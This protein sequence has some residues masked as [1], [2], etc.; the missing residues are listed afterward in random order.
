MGGITRPTWLFPSR[1]EYGV[2]CYQERALSGELLLW[3]RD[4]AAELLAG[5]S[6]NCDIPRPDDLLGLRYCRLTHAKALSL[7]AGLDRQGVAVESLLAQM[8]AWPYQNVA[9][10]WLS[11]PGQNVALLCQALEQEGVSSDS[12]TL[13][14]ARQHRDVI[15]ALESVV[16]LGARLWLQGRLAA[17]AHG[18]SASTDLPF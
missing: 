15:L 6:G 16:P 12:R 3:L 7:L 8:D 18:A 17:V 5:D 10:D 13:A 11:E 14:R 4:Q 2:K 9:L 1:E